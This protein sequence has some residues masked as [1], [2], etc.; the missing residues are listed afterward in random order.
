LSLASLE[1]AIPEGEG[2]LLDTSTLIAYL[3]AGEAVTPV[4]SHVITDW[5][6]GGRN[7]AVVSMVSVTEV[8]LQPLRAGAEEAYA[9]LIEFLT[10]FPNMRLAP[11]DLHTAQ[12]AAW[13]RVASSLTPPNALII[14][15]GVMAQAG[16]LV[17]NDARWKQAEPMA[18]NI[19]AVY[20]EDHLPFP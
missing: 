10:H 11:I 8:L 17:T 18:R 2:L 16:H 19:R 13:L 3:N 14:A 20:L 7:P 12:E 6:G 4:A 15:T 5:V 1:E 9:T